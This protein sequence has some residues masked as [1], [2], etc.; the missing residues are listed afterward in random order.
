LRKPVAG[1]IKALHRCPQALGLFGQRM[2]LHLSGQFH[3]Y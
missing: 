1:S 2:Q 3:A